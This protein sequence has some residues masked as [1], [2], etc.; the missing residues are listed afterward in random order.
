MHVCQGRLDFFSSPRE[1]YI[2]VSNTCQ[3]HSAFKPRLDIYTSLI[4]DEDLGSLTTLT[5][6]TF[7]DISFHE[8]Y[9][10]SHDGVEQL[11]RFLPS[12]KII[13][14]MFDKRARQPTLY[15]NYPEEM[16]SHIDW[17]GIVNID[18]ITGEP[19]VSLR[20]SPTF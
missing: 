7:L 16:A 6:L 18:S 2:W 14:R 13:R 8:I 10:L 1:M 11:S 9:H 17:L 4:N 15:Y 20:S 19:G 5:T 3:L 12:T